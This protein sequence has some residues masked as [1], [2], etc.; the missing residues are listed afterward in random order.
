VFTQ[1]STSPLTYKCTQIKDRNGNYLTINYD[2]DGNLSSVVD[3]LGRTISFVYNSSHYLA[4][5]DQTWG[6]STTHTWATFTYA[7]LQ[8]DM[9]YSGLTLVGASNGQS[10]TVLSQ[11]G[12]PDGSSVTFTY[13]SYAQISKISHVAADS[14]SHILSYTSYDFDTT[15]SQTDCPRITARR[16]WAENWNL[17]T[18]GQPDY[19]S[20]TA[21]EAVTTFSFFASG[22][23]WPTISGGTDSGARMR[24][25]TP[26]GVRHRLSFHNPSMALW[27]K[28][29]LQY[30]DTQVISGGIGVVERYSYTTW[31]QDDISASYILNPRVT[32][33]NAFDSVNNRHRATTDYTS[34][35]VSTGAAVKLPSD[36]SEYGSDGAVYRKSHTD[37]ITSQTYLDLRIIGLPSA[38]YLYDVGHSNAVVSHSEFLYDDGG[39]FLAN[40]PG[41]TQH[42]D[43]NFSSTFVVGRGNLTKTRVYDVQGSGYLES[44]IKY[45][46]TGTVSSTVDL[47]G[48]AGSI[49]YTDTFSINPSSPTYAY[50]TTITDAAGFSATSQYNY[51]F[52]A[53]VEAQDPKHAGV[54]ITYDSVGRVLRKTSH[55]S[56]GVLGAYTRYVYPSQSSQNILQSF[57]LV[58]AGEAEAYS[59]QVF[60]GAGRVLSTS[61]DFPGSTGGYKGQKT[62]YDVMGRAVMHSHATEMNG[63]WAATGDDSP[64]GTGYGWIFTTQTY[65]WAGRPLVTTNPDATNPDG[66]PTALSSKHSVSYVDT[67]GIGTVVTTEDEMHRKVRVTPDFQGRT[68]KTEVLDSTNS[69]SVYKTTTITYTV[70]DQVTNVEERDPNTQTTQNTIKT[71]D[72]FGRVLTAKSPIASSASSYTYNSEGLL[73]TATD[74]RG[75]VTTYTYNNRHQTTG[76]SAPSGVTAALSISYGYD[77][78]GNRTSMSDGTGSHTYSYDTW[79]RM[80]SETQTFSGLP[81][82]YT[83]SYT[84]NLAGQLTSITTPFSQTPNINKTVTYDYDKTGQLLTV[85]GIGFKSGSGNSGT[86]VDVPHFASNFKFRAWGA[87][88]HMEY[89]NDLTVNGDTQIPFEA[90][91]NRRLQLA[92]L[93]GDT[94]HSGRTEIQYYDDGQV[95]TIFG[96]SKNNDGTYQLAPSIWDKKFTYDQFGRMQTA[97]TGDKARGGSTS[98]GPYNETYQHDVF[99]NLTQRQAGFWSQGSGYVTTYVNNRDQNQ[100][101]N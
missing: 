99:N 30:E 87:L 1:T 11:V 5:I 26:D 17:Q 86:L 50:P 51:D 41:A 12:F 58:K 101:A 16:D 36:S 47:G 79:N 68:L 32:E 64:N 15:S 77:S 22:V 60:D 7:S 49:S 40:Q 80:T 37:Y 35:S 70:L 63:S 84:Y 89:A 38:K 88:K 98:D 57:T 54:S 100:G 85:D 72:G 13:N 69:D 34:I 91:Y 83:L 2:H 61:A 96:A 4:E 90:E 43:T 74:A 78:M 14:T 42:D 93:Y 66:T 44:Q 29:L 62:Y 75:V 6:G 18:N 53:V 23:T 46:S 21:T 45:F 71:Y 82:S 94:N 8:L 76:V 31:T 9:H 20:G 81:G 24:I 67:M 73:S 65:D 55:D 97:Y 92:Y 19:Q 27:D 33:T 28:G 25:L 39:D 56:G 48:H 52:G 10:V 95:N 3:T 59:A